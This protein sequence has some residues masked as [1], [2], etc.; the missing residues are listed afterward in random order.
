MYY[1]NVIDFF[2]LQ[3]NLFLNISRPM[4]INYSLKLSKKK[5]KISI[6]TIMH[7]S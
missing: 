3:T 5:Y 2:G 1:Q 6:N 4:L 7:T